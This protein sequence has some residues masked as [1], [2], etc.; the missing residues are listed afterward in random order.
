LELPASYRPAGLIWK[1]DQSR[2]APTRRGISRQDSTTLKQ[3]RRFSNAL[4][5]PLALDWA[6]T[7]HVGAHRAIEVRSS[8]VAQ[9]LESQDGVRRTPASLSIRDDFGFWRDPRGAEDGLHL[10]RGFEE[11][12]GPVHEFRPFEV[13]RTRQVA[14]TLGGIVSRHRTGVLVDGAN[15]PKESISL[16][17][18]IDRLGQAAV[19]AIVLA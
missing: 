19:E 8:F 1:R 11:A 12:R 14:R 7:V 5:T 16:G 13:H 10:V 3:P 4:I 17:R 9:Q 18:G 2:S 6:V 15:V